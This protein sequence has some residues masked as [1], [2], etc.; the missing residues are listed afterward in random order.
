MARKA[1]RTPLEVA[2][3][4]QTEKNARYEAKRREAGL[5]RVSVWVPE[6]RK[7]DLHELA[8][9]MRDGER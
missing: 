7:A 1:R 4:K 5:V 6:G 3:A 9:Q 2:I 8:R